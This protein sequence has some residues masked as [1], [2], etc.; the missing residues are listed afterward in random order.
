MVISAKETTSM[1]LDRE[2]KE[3]AKNI[4]ITRPLCLI[5]KMLNII[6]LNLY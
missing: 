4:S 5:H 2:V 3:K 1:K 6:V